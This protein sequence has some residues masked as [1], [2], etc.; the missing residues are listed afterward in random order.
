MCRTGRK[1]S[2]GERRR[3]AMVSGSS[4]KA[5]GSALLVS[6]MAVNFLQFAAYFPAI[7]TDIVSRLSELLRVRFGG[8]GYGMALRLCKRRFFPGEWLEEV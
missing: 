4:Y 3:E 5:V 2:R 7:V 1:G 6:E 8:E